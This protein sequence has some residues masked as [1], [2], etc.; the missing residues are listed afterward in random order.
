MMKI[1]IYFL[2]LA[3]MAGQILAQ[4]NY[5]WPLQPFNEQHWINGTFCE[6]RPDGTVDI[7]HFH[8]GV[9][10]HL[11]QYGNVYA[12]V[13]GTVTAIGTAAQYGINAYVRV[14]RYAYV[15]VDA[16]PGLQV[17]DA[18]TA[19]Q[20][21]IGKT[22]SW[23]HIHFKDGYAGSEINGLRSDGGL[24]P[25][26][27]PYLPT[28][29]SV[30][31][32]VNATT[33]GF[34]G[35][36]VSGKVDIVAKASDKTDTGPVGNN[37]GIYAIG[38][39]VFDSTGTTSLLGPIRNFVFSNIPSNSYIRRVFFPGSDISNYYYTISNKPER[40]NYWDTSDWPKGKYK[41]LVTAEDTRF[42]VVE[43]WVDVRVVDE[44]LQPPVAP[45]L[46]QLAG[47]NGGSWNLNWLPNDSSDVA[48]Y[49]MYFSLDGVNFALNSFISGQIAAVDTAW[50]QSGFPNEMPL[51]I[52]LKAYDTA[53]LTNTSG[54]SSTYGLRLSPAG[55]EV[56]IVDGYHREDGYNGSA[57][58]DIALHYGRMLDDHGI[59]FNTISS[60]LLERGNFDL[61]MY[62]IVLY[63]CGDETAADK[64][65]TETEQQLLSGYLEQGGR[66]FI[67]GSNIGADL[68]VTAN[69]FYTNYLHAG[70]IADSSESYSI[71]G[72]SGSIFEGG[73]FDLNPN[74]VNHD[75]IA[76]AGSAA[77]LNWLN[78]ST[79]AVQYEGI[80]GSGSTAGKLVY[81]AFPLDL[82]SDLNQQ[83][84]ILFN[85]L[86]WFGNPLTVEPSED[87]ALP[88][89]M[90]LSANYPNPFNPV[91][92]FS[93]ALPQSAWL[94]VTVYN[95]AGELIT[96]LYDGSMSAGSHNFTWNGTNDR[97]QPVGSG[98]YLLEVRSG[99]E[100]KMRK[101]LLLH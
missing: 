90:Q 25:F 31:F 43:R 81:F 50:S 76:P 13:S 38:Y 9:D 26:E 56:L 54:F 1:T 70:F 27:D 71:T 5:N 79:A 100:R 10:I 57:T 85:I 36:R 4:T 47:D 19:F 40:D 93:V 67:A 63:F 65:I 33:I 96:R 80:F 97:G 35:N 17:G 98:V 61:E 49:E 34:S 60:K 84:E 15:H 72:V 95:S 16:V 37:N 23:N 12:V 91:T 55:P 77:T 21:V 28:I 88:A 73:T 6:N 87:A 39:E 66:L 45:Q 82:V 59:A 2:L 92:R 8:D 58:H 42:N 51:F 83:K 64:T 75:V 48:G 62:P 32:Y 89:R 94:T 20:T 41:L 99:A 52:R 14:G 69:T 74:G 3:A 22:N 78:G 24:S 29:E 7:D 68:S 53:A 101:M 11:P 30:Q 44:D 18:V 46:L 86:S